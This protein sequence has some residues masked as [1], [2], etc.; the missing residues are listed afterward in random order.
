M[1]IVKTPEE[2]DEFIEDDII[3]KEFDDKEKER[4]SEM[5]GN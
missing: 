2:I 3:Q 1:E 5:L 4:K